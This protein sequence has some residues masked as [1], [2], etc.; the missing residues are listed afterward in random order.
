[1][2]DLQESFNQITTFSFMLEELQTAV[3]ANDTQRIVD[4]TAALNAFYPVY[5]DKWDRN[6][7]VA[8][9]HVV[10]EQAWCH[11]ESGIASNFTLGEK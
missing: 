11:P 8:W 3:D 4:V 6:F 7:N 10:K 1:M 2:N 9:D 5:V